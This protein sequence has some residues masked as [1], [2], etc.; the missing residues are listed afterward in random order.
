MAKDLVR[1]GV[2]E[3]TEEVKDLVVVATNPGEMQEAQSALIDWASR[4]L[5][6]LATELGDY[7]TGLEKARKNRWNAGVLTRAVQRV[8]KEINF[9][10]KVH[11]ALKEGYCIIP[12]M[13]MDVFA[14]RTTKK[15]PKKNETTRWDVDDQKTSSPP[16][17]EG[18]YVDPEATVL[19]RI[20]P[21]AEG[22]VSGQEQRWAEKFQEVDFPFVMAK[23]RV[24]DQTEKALTLKIFDELGI[25]PGRPGRRPTMPSKMN[26]SMNNEHSDPMVIGRISMK[27]GPYNR[28]KEISFLVSW[29]VDTRDL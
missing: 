27:T 8:E 14:I 2:V 5:A 28:R 15:R 13:P 4:K 7:K 9:Y 1:S 25:L 22:Q 10:E 23:P 21:A 12:N 3:E 20:L 26:H 29:F 11:E 19:R 6:S 16:I 17:G 18:R 24:L